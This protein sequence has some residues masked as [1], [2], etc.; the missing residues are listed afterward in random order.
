MR[1]YIHKLK[2][3]LYFTLWPTRVN[4][5]TVNPIL[6]ETELIFIDR[7]IQLKSILLESEKT[8][9][10]ILIILSLSDFLV[11]IIYLISF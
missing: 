1:N 6:E 4:I 7:N 5:R 9:V 8:L 10:I 3:R 2:S 11:T